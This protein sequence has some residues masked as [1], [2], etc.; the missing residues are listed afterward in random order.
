MTLM[1]TR[2]PGTSTGSFAP[3]RTGGSI[4]NHDCHS[5]FIPT[6]SSGSRRMK[7]ALSTFSS[8]LQAPDRYPF[9]SQGSNQVHVSQAPARLSR[10]GH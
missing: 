4:G 6:K 8:E 9:A 1:D 2:M 10:P 5:S 3:C 7:V